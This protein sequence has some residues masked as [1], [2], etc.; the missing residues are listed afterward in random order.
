MSFRNIAFNLFI[1]SGMLF[2]GI[3]SVGITRFFS[4]NSTDIKSEVAV[5]QPSLKPTAI[6]DI[7]DPNSVLPLDY[8]EEEL[9]SPHVDE[10]NP[11]FFD[12]E[13][14][15]YLDE[16]SSNDSDEFH[17]FDIYNKNFD[18]N[19]K[20]DRY[21]ELIAPSG[22]LFAGDGSK[23]YSFTSIS[24]SNGKLTF[25]TETVNGVAYEFS[26]EFLIKGNFYTLDPNAKVLKGTLTKKINGKRS[27]LKELYFGWTI[28]EGC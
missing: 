28:D 16:S 10:K 20:D 23:S 5:N 8:N 9:T 11:E 12:P 21:G 26:G 7:N 2:F 1:A 3:A 19:V 17:Y 13:G 22:N 15:Y 14:S 4:G 25:A 27:K 6:F 24:I 18:V